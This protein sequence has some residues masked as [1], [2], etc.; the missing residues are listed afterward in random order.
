MMHDRS[1]LAEPP[2][3]RAVKWIV[4]VIL[5]VITLVPWA[6]ILPQSMVQTIE[7]PRIR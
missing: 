4:V 6:A 1:P 5:A 7:L 3:E 2:R